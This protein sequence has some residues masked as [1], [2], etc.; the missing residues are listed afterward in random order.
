VQLRL[1][2]IAVRAVQRSLLPSIARRRAWRRWS[3]RTRRQR[4]RVRRLFTR[5]VCA[6]LPL[7][8]IVINSVAGA[9]IGIS[10]ARSDDAQPRTLTFWLLGGLG[11]ANWLEII[12]AAIPVSIGAGLLLGTGQ[13]LNAF[14]LG[15]RDASLPAERSPSAAASRLSVL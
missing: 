15:E 11:G 13:A 9:C 8:G 10:T 14:S 2:W 1:P 6:V 4:D 3:R 12:A 5:K 7:A